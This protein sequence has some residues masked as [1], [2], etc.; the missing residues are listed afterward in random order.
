MDKL[1]KMSQ[2][3]PRHDMTILKF[4]MTGVLAIVNCNLMLNYLISMVKMGYNVHG[5]SISMLPCLAIVWT[6]MNCIFLFLLQK[7]MFLWEL[8]NIL[9][10]AVLLCYFAD[11]PWGFEMFNDL[12]VIIFL[13]TLAAKYLWLCLLNFNK[14]CQSG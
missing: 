12:L 7:K 3:R 10:A 4:I 13:L 5:P 8:F 2:F 9:M 11:P 6:V 14:W 1:A